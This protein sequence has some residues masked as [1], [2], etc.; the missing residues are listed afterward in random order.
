MTIPDTYDARRGLRNWG[1]FGNNVDG[2][3]IV[4]AIENLRMLHNV[5]AASTWKRF[6]YRL[7]FRPPHTPFVLQEYADF[8]LTQG[9]KPSPSTGVDPLQFFTWLKVTKKIDDFQQIIIGQNNNIFYDEKKNDL[10]REACV[11]WNGCLLTLYL[12]KHAYDTG[13]EHKPW[14]LL[15]TDPPSYSL[16][17]AVAMVAYSKTS[18][19]VVTWGMMKEMTIGFTDYTVYGC[20]VFR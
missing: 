2:D 20:W 19:A 8:L 1:M 14:S 17:H 7:G 13:L 18:N 15:T 16:A 9:E 4:V 11:G 12:T 10:I 5:A 6:M 3:C